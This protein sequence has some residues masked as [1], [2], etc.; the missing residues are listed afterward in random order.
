MELPA[1]AAEIALALLG[2]CVGSFL[3]VCIH[4]LPL[5][6]SV[7]QPRS[8]RMRRQASMMSI[9]SSWASRSV[10]ELLNHG[11]SDCASCSN[12][13]REASRW[14][15]SASVTAASGRSQLG[16]PGTSAARWNHDAADR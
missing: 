12:S 6:Q 2:L 14:P 9:A 11:S 7:V 16:A 1:G 3:N 10:A 15:P 5:K 4:R 8:R 13:A